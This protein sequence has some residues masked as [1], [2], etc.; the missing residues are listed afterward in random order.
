MEIMSGDNFKKIGY[1]TIAVSNRGKFGFAAL[2][3]ILIATMIL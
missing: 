3:I 1:K 2:P